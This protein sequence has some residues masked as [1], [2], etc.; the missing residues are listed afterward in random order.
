MRVGRRGRR[1]LQYRRQINAEMFRLPRRGRPPDDPAAASCLRE[2][3]GQSPY[4]TTMFHSK[5][6]IFEEQRDEESFI[7][8]FD[9]AALREAMTA[10]VFSEIRYCDAHLKAYV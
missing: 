6:V 4:P 1:P 8:S 10:K 5:L 9:L 3:E 7:R 2:R